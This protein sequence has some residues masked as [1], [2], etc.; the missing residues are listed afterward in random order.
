MDDLYLIDGC[1]FTEGVFIGLSER[2]KK[3]LL[4][5]FFSPRQVRVTVSASVYRRSAVSI[6]LP[7]ARTAAL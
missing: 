2:V 1:T 5:A 3:S 6:T 7:T 4:T